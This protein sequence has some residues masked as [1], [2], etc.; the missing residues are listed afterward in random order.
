M[1]TYYDTANQPPAQG[2]SP[3]AEYS[4]AEQIENATLIHN[5]LTQNLGF[6][7]NSACA[8]IGNIQHESYLNPAQ[9]EVSVGATTGGYGL[10][11][12]TPPANVINYITNRTDGYEQC[13]W[14]NDCVSALG[15]WIDVMGFGSWTDFKA[16]TDDAYYL[17]QVFLRNY[18]RGLSVERRYTNARYW[19]E[20]F[21]PVPPPP[22]TR[23][24]GKIIFYLRNPNHL[25]RRM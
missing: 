20:Y 10:V 7:T 18:E 9:W 17:A 1:F 4:S 2:W 13:Q 15:Q 22:P 24:K 8:V 5:Y 12:W 21:E 23:E 14:I 16:S 11:Q 6:T 3:I 19:Y 25:I